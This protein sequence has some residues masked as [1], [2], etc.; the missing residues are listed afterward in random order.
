MFVETVFA[1][2]TAVFSFED[3]FCKWQEYVTAMKSEVLSSVHVWNVFLIHCYEIA[4]FE[5]DI[6]K[7]SKNETFPQ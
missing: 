7:G 2:S 6:S 4:H 1:G 5:T 3:F